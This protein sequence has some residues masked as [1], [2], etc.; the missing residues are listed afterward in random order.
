[1][2]GSVDFTIDARFEEAL[3]YANIP[4]LLMV[5]VHLTGQTSWLEEPFRPKRS[6]GLDDNDSGGLSAGLQ[7]EVR[8]AALEAILS[9]YHGRVPV[10][11]SQPTP[12]L[13]V[14]MLSWSMDEPVPPEYGP[15][16]AAD[17]DAS[18]RPVLPPRTARPA[19]TSER[20]N[21]VI[22]GAGVSGICAALAFEREG[23]PY[24]ILERNTEV[25]GTWWENRY[26]GAGIDTPNHLYSFSGIPHDWQHYFASR[27]ELF[28]YLH[29]VAS[30]Y[31]VRDR[32]QLQ[33][34]AVSAVYDDAR[35]VW[36]VSAVDARG[37]ATDYV[38]NILITAVGGFN[39]PRTPDI[40]G[41]DTF[42]GPVLHTARWPEDAAIDGA[43][44]AVVGN[45][46]SAMQLIPAIADR[47]GTLTIFQRSPQWAAPFEKFQARVP[48]QLRFLI[49]AV[50]LYQWWYRT[51]LHWTFNDRLHASLQRD[52]N[53]PNAD[54]S[55]NATNDAHRRYFVRYIEAELGDRHDLV[56]KVVPNYPP[57]GKRILLD[58]GWYRTLLRDNVEL[59]AE[60]LNRVSGN[61]L[62]T[63]SGEEHRAS[64]L[65]MATG[66]DVVHFLSTIDIHGRGGRRIADVWDGDDGRAY[67]GCAVP[68]FPN[69]FCLYGPNT[70]PGHG[71][72]II[73]SI[74]AQVHYLIGLLQQME[75]SGL[76]AIE[77]RGDVWAEHNAEIDERHAR[78]V[79]THPK[80]D[81]YYQNSRGRVVV[82]SPFRNVDYWYATRESLLDDYV[83]EKATSGTRTG[84]MNESRA[85]TQ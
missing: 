55:L 56:S 48:E 81:T 24:T 49:G 7:R 14:R 54:R 77:C 43:N 50:P 8:A 66:F 22:I 67:L 68:G 31:G 25:G 18:Q 84:M 4:V 35:Q 39:T 70:Q 46:A 69:M 76:G 1:M 78:M 21:A 34:T 28:E 80:V 40:E 2:T 20:M 71:G 11:I 47:V 73:W 9:W 42:A 63:E 27:D 59:V 51:R 53:W 37:R 26:P 30:E 65:I 3:A 16:M 38:A 6:G 83:V 15:M 60:P 45:G 33:T 82:N 72:S 41:L 74:E 19:N 36:S 64:T 57:Y 13:L 29:Q 79:W 5:L 58:N 32:I 44:V 85:T 17:L 12:E 61:S 52:P 75:R 23:I 62:F 10:A